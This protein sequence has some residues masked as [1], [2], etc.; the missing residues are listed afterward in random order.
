MYLLL[1][2]ALIGG[3]LWVAYPTGARGRRV[4]RGD[5]RARYLRLL[6]MPPRLGEET[7]RR[8]LADLQARLPGHSTAWYL[9][10]MIA[11]LER[12]RR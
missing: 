5:L 4:R 2:V 6:N 12:D 1:A 7:L 3:L 8:T 11:D 10:K 9:R